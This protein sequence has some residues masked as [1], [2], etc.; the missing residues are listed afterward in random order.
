MKVLIVSAEF[1]PLCGGV[2]RFA[3]NLAKGLRDL[4]VSVRV[5][6]ASAPDGGESIQAV[7]VRRTPAL[8]NRKYL[9]IAP[10]LCAALGMCLRHRPDWVLAM[11]WTHDGVV[12]W[13]LRKML[14][15]RYALVAHGSEILKHQGRSIRRGLMLR[16][17]GGAEAVITNSEFTKGLLDRLGI[18]RGGVAVVNPP[19]DPS[20]WPPDLGTAEID[21][22]FRL[23]G[24]RV[25]LTA[26]RLVR[27]KGHEQ[28]IRI[29][30]EIRERYPDLVY[31]ITGGGELGRELRELAHRHGVEDRVRMTGYLDRSTLRRFFARA[32]VYISPSLEDQGDVEG[33]G[34]SLAEAGACGKPVIAGKVGGVPET[35]AHGETGLLVD[36]SNQDE[37]V[38]ALR[39]LLDD[40]GLRRRLGENGRARATGE[41]GIRAQSS[42][43][44]DSL[45]RTVGGSG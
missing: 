41:F 7:E 2:G 24:K 21:E 27:R 23:G 19:V 42:R 15:I 1:P 45:Q 44:M 35:V 22:R 32:E 13:A 36:A 8:L 29:L 10:L 20:E 26:G 17:F 3:C 37:I 6:T 16:I 5:L 11:V 12:A 30:G 43:L 33:F 28:V 14:G 34:I 4:N 18:G 38:R 25:L 9:K 31:V 39:A 40:E